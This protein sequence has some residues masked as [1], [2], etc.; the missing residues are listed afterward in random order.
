MRRAGADAV[1]AHHRVPAFC[2]PPTSQENDVKKSF[3]V[4]AALLT[5]FLLGAQAPAAAAQA[6]VSADGRVTMMA[7]QARVALPAREDA[8][9]FTE[10]Y[11]TFNKD[12][13]N[14]Y[15]C[16]VGWTL[17]S[18]DS[19]VGAQQFVGMPFTPTQNFSLRKV[20]LGLSYVTGANAL[21][22]SLR[23]DAGG[24]P[25]DIINRFKV[26]GAPSA[27]SCCEVVTGTNKGIPLT[28]GTTYWLVVKVKADTWGA[29]NLNNIGASGPFAF[30][31]GEGTHWRTTSD[32]LGA[33]RVLGE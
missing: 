2:F 25:G 7:P 21:Y 31:Q 33:F 12:R 23:A 27:G 14:L 11:S 17:S 20:Q 4:F 30:N 1:Q 22:V 13:D 19:I 26:A 9:N 8:G 5:T 29:W 3:A 16:C 10:I 18:T 6:S 24:V 28:A 32:V 15:D